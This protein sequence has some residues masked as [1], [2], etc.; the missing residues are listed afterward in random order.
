MNK[1]TNQAGY[2]EVQ[3]VK[4]HAVPCMKVQYTQVQMKYF[5]MNIEVHTQNIYNITR[6]LK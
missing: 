3:C 6:K 1:T 4:L 2:S 5:N